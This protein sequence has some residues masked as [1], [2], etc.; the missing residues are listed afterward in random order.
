MSANKAAEGEKDEDPI[1]EDAPEAS[2]AAEPIKR[3]EMK[4]TVAVEAVS[5]P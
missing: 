4:Q 2:K 3:D 5:P 1:I